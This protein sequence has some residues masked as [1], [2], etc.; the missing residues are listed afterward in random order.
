M[1]P[2]DH[3]IQ[4]QMAAITGSL[5]RLT[6]ENDN[7]GCSSSEVK[8]KWSHTFTP[9]LPI[10]RARGTI[11]PSSLP[12]SS[13]LSPSSSSSS[14]FDRFLQMV[15]FTLVRPKFEYTCAAYHSVSVKDTRS[16]SASRGSSCQLLSS[17]LHSLTSTLVF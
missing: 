12:A 6:I 11:L 2:K 16:F 9:A 1:V 13:S 10:S 17:F 14:S 7:A 4:L 5:K 8:N 15:R 3:L